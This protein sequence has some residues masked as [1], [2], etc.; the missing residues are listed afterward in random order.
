MQYI[1]DLQLCDSYKIC[2]CFVCVWGGGFLKVPLAKF[3]HYRYSNVLEIYYINV[4]LLNVL[5]RR[6]FHN[7]FVHKG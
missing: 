2:V 6:N 5:N 4:S 1:Q 7:K 3:K